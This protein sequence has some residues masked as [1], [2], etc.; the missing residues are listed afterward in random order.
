MEELTE[1]LERTRRVVTR[2]S[3]TVHRI[4]QHLAVL[5]SRH[6]A[7]QF[8]SEEM[9]IKGSVDGVICIVTRT[10]NDPLEKT[11]R[12]LAGKSELPTII[13]ADVAGGDL[14]TLEALRYIRNFIREQGKMRFAMV[15]TW[16]PLLP[17]LEKASTLIIGRRYV[18]D[19]EKRIEGIRQRLESAGMHVEND[20]GE[21]G[22]GRITFTLCED[23]EPFDTLAV[24]VTVP[25]SLT[26]NEKRI[27]ELIRAF[28]D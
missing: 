9:V 1:G 11:I 27:I 5:E 6:V 3:S 15:M 4:N 8:S 24:E 20:I 19:P 17:P 18:H 28:Y 26:G 14:S 23:L 10:D 25:E 21:Y 12:R 13:I 2:I 22:G 7:R 16:A